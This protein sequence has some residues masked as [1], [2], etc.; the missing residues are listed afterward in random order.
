MCPAY[1]IPSRYVLSNRLLDD[2]CARIK[3]IVK[4]YLKSSLAG[5]FT[6]TCDGWTNIENYHVVKI[7][8][9]TPT[10]ILYKEVETGDNSH[11]GEYLAAIIKEGILSVGGMV[12][13]T[14]F[15][16]RGISA[17]VTDKYSA[18]KNAWRIFKTD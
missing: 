3:H 8:T 16:S 1:E 6:M 18:M 17:I 2:E 15:T 9:A 7:M 11:T 10:T 5:S 13:H 12:D 14:D 4:H